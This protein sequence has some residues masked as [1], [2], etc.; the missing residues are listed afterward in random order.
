MF[1]V[2]SFIGLMAQFQIKNEVFSTLWNNYP[3]AQ[4]SHF[5][6]AGYWYPYEG[7][8]TA[9]FMTPEGRI[10]KKE[11]PNARSPLKVFEDLSG[12]KGAWNW[13]RK[14]HSC[15][16]RSKD[17]QEC[18]SWWGHCNGWAAAAVKESEPSQKIIIGNTLISPAEQEALLSE[19][20]LT[21]H[22]IFVG[23]T[24]KSR[25]TGNW[26][27]TPAGKAF[28]DVE[29]R[30]FFLILT[31]YVGIFKAPLVIDRFTGY[32]VWNTPL[33]AYRFLPISSKDIS[34]A[35]L[36]NKKVW[37]VKLRV[38][39]YMV[40]SVDVLPGQATPGFNLEK[41]TSDARDF[42]PNPRGVT[43]YSSRTLGFKLWFDGPVE[44]NSSGQVVQVGR[45]V[46]SGIWEHQEEAF[47]TG[48][49]NLD[50][51]HPD[52]IW[53]PTNP[54]LDRSG[55][56]NPYVNPNTVFSIIKTRNFNGVSLT[57]SR[58]NISRHG[59][60]STS[61]VNRDLTRSELET[62]VRLSLARFGIS[63]HVTVEDS[64]SQ[65]ETI[66]VLIEANASP[67]ELEEAL[68]LLGLI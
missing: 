62:V 20:W 28:W 12:I 61:R 31:N 8:G 32:Q 13:E 38:K 47:K 26:I 1:L 40:P 25:K 67:G 35:T 45:M 30:S 58:F 52:F 37:E 14:N 51:T 60:H 53:L 18:R 29:P 64:P 41:H 59:V 68:T 65:P 66:P 16:P 36:D 21:T 46:G 49:T 11:G 19:A 22:S 63:A 55:Y 54:Y 57:A 15:D 44:V 7:Y 9:L 2:T 48:N 17:Y 50:D 42:L 3:R 56:G 43:I 5:V 4:C 6:W 23:T 39:I 24:D 34:I 10:M 27:F 33:I